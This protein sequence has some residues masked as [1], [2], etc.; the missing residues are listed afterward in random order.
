MLLC[1]PFWPRLYATTTV[2]QTLYLHYLQDK[3]LVSADF[4]TICFKLRYVVD[5][6]IQRIYAGAQFY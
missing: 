1:A 2:V 6:S 4:E 3:R 5:N